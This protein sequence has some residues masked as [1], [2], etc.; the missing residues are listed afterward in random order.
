MM[1]DGV[2]VDTIKLLP[3]TTSPKAATE[4]IQHERA[5]MTERKKRSIPLT[6]GAPSSARPFIR[7]S[8]TLES[9]LERPAHPSTWWSAGNWQGNNGPVSHTAGEGAKKKAA[10]RR[11]LRGPTNIVLLLAW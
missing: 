9:I 1:G 2:P 4:A 6:R 10:E 7:A 3:L 11:D 5:A 8:R